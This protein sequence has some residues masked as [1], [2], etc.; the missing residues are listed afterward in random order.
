MFTALHDSVERIRRVGVID[1]SLLSL[2]EFAA[3]MRSNNGAKF[4]YTLVNS[5]QIAAF[6]YGVL[7]AVAFLYVIC[8]VI[9]QLT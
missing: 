4:F 7:L 9:L 8:G 6:L 5:D 3:Y 1:F 2:E